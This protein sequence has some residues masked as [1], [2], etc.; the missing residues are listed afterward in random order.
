MEGSYTNT[1]IQVEE[2]QLDTAVDIKQ[3]EV[4]EGVGLISNFLLTEAGQQPSALQPE[5][6][7]LLV[8]PECG[9]TRRIQQEMLWYSSFKRRAKISQTNHQEW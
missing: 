5:D 1:G 6:N 8:K 9:G 2:T 4:G 7:F 3:L